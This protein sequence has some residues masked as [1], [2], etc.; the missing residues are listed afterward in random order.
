MV[1][2]GLG[3]NG[4]PSRAEG[5]MTVNNDMQ[6]TVVSMQDNME[7]GKRTITA[8]VRVGKNCENTVVITAENCE[9]A[10][11]ILN[12]LRVGCGE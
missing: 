2:G 8:Q 4:G 6:V 12:A 9:T 10:R 1:A 5:G 3:Y 11:T 7:T